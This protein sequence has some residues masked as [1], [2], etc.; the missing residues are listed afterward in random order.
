MT[1]EEHAGGH[2][3]RNRSEF[4]YATASEI[5]RSLH[6][7]SKQSAQRECQKSL[8]PL[9]V[10]WYPFDCEYIEAIETG[11]SLSIS[12]LKLKWSQRSDVDRALAV[13]AIRRSGTSIRQIA[14][15][16][17]RSESTLRHLLKTLEA[18]A[19]DQDLARRKQISTSELIRRGQ[20]A[21]LKRAEQ[22]RE[23]LEIKREES[24]R[25]AADLICNW[26]CE[27]HICGP[28]GELIIDEVRSKLDTLKDAGLRPHPLL[29]RYRNS[30]MT[31]IIELS[32]PT[33]QA[34][35]DLPIDAHYVTWLLIW[36]CAAFPDAQ[37]RDKALEL[38]LKRQREE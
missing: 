24:A 14:R 34:N 6:T 31:Q 37:V 21:S 28:D 15:E 35:D 26:I 3:L 16:L 17:E 38:A 8:H 20:V 32:R 2:P 5:H 7:P 23:M 29:A 36:V 33:E 11:L 10:N 27:Q 25:K 4:S 9:Q 13:A 30:T 12:Q 22:H 1:P 19:D 18:S